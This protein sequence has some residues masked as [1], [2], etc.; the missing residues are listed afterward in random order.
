MI[1][2]S[3]ILELCYKGFM[4]RVCGLWLSPKYGLR[5]AAE[6]NLYLRL[7]TEKIRAFAVFIKKYLGNTAEVTR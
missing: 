3:L 5:L 1:N 7:P 6:K 2:N 4:F